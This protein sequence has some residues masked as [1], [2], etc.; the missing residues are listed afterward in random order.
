[1]V[2]YDCTITNNY[3]WYWPSTSTK[4]MQLHRYIHFNHPLPLQA[5]AIPNRSQTLLKSWIIPSHPPSI[6]KRL[7]PKQD[8]YCLWYGGRSL[9]LFI[10]RWFGPIL[11]TPARRTLLPTRLI[12]GSH[13]LPYEERLRR[14]GPHSLR[15]R[16]LR[17][18]LI[19]AYKMF[20]R[21]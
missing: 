4:Q 20:S 19:A 2:K 14:L 3:W 1:M 8:G 21:G 15:R 13:R 7:P 12:Q 6:A 17:G 16:R 9:T 5:R 18:D 11:S 10:T